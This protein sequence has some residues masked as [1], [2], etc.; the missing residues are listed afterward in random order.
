MRLSAPLDGTWTKADKP[1]QNV[2]RF[3]LTTSC[4]ISKKV[5]FI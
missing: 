3:K 4:A 1:C 5:M 2:I